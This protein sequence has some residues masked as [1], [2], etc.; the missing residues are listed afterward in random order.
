VK[1]SIR[2]PEWD[3]RKSS[4]IQ[5][6]CALYISTAVSNKNDSFS[7]D[8]RSTQ[9]I[10]KWKQKILSLV[11]QPKWKKNLFDGSEIDID[12]YCRFF[13]DFKS[14]RIPNT[15]IFSDKKKMPTEIAFSVLFDQ[16][17]STDSWVNNQHIIQIIKGSLVGLKELLHEVSPK[18]MVSGTY[19]ATRN[20]CNLVL[21]KSFNEG[22]S[23]YL[24]RVHAIEPKGYTRL[25]PSIRH[26]TKEL[27]NC[28]V[29]KKILLLIS[30]GKPTDLDYY[31]G[32]RGIKDVRKARLE[33][34]A[35]G[36]TFVSI[37]LDKKNRSHFPDMF[38]RYQVIQSPDKFLPVFFR[39]VYDGFQYK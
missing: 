1:S 22:W 35:V 7:L 6:Y 33:A 26:V 8:L 19:S 17:L 5:D 30:D 25:G 36:I 21:Y 9:Q 11:D 16:S 12:G 13:S 18:V 3:D 27:V 37:I 39:L 24:S 23:D 29:Q 31:E 10:N 4:Y 38:S 34:E 2:Y 32:Q 14:G 15:K 20:N 28:P